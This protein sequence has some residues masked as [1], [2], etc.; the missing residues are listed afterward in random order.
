MADSDY[1][2]TYMVRCNDR[3]LYSGI[4]KDPEKRLREHNTGKNGARYT[5][6]RRPV[7]LVYQ[8][9]FTSRSAAARREYQLKQLSRAMKQKLMQDYL[10]S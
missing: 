10:S 2:Y 5:R 4:A 9:K 8:E 6:S 3:S 1:W 7:Q